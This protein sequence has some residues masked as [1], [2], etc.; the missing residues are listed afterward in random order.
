LK[1]ALGPGEARNEEEHAGQAGQGQAEVTPA[2]AGPEKQRLEE[3][4]EDRE[5]RISQQPHG[6]GRDA[7]RL[8]KEDPMNSQDQALKEKEPAVDFTADRKPASGKADD[9]GQGRGGE[10]DPS[11][12]D[13]VRPKGQP[14]AEK[15]GQPEQRDGRMDGQQASGSAHGAPI[16][17]KI[18]FPGRPGLW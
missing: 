4:R 3:G 1:N 12:D 17:T 9:Q 15:T 18:P 10:N 5:A 13:E 14:L 8:E 6:H 2:E 11:E 7:D 16:I